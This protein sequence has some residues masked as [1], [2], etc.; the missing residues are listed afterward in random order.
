M[1][2]DT[3]VEGCCK[4]SKGAILMKSVLRFVILISLIMNSSYSFAQ[5]A[6]AGGGDKGMFENSMKDVFTVI[7]TGIGGAVLGLST[8]SFAEEPKDNLKNVVTGAAIGIILGVGIVAYKAAT[9]NTQQYNENAYHQ[10]DLKDFSTNERL[11]WHENKVAASF[12]QKGVE[13]PHFSYQ[14]SF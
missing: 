9:K 3:F 8:L 5:E 14:F 12:Y 1:Y 6:A 7:G 11:R 10:I 13:L 2:Y 4:L